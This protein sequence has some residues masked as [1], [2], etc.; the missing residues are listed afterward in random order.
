MY[1]DTIL[2]KATIC[3]REVKK[4]APNPKGPKQQEKPNLPKSPKQPYGEPLKGSKK[5]KNANHSRQKKGASHD[6]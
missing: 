3:I 6:M 2:S 1:K 5:V 4:M